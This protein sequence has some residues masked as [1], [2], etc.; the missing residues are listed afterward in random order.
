MM[1][2]RCRECKYYCSEYKV[3]YHGVVEGCSCTASL[4]YPSCYEKRKDADDSRED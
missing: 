4:S 2:L 3:Q 1:P